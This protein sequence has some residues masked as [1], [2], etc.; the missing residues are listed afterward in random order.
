MKIREKNKISLLSKMI[1]LAVGSAVLSACQVD[2]SVDGT[3]TG[4]GDLLNVA[5]IA[6]ADS[7]SINEDGILEN[8]NVLANDTD[9]N[10]DVL[11]VSEATASTGSVVINGDNTLTY[12]PAADF[13]GE[14]VVT[15]TVNDGT[16]TAVGNLTVTVVAVN[17]DPVAVDDTVVVD[18]NS[19]ANSIAVLDNDSDVEDT[20]LTIDSA[21]A[22]FGQVDIVGGEILYT[23]LSDATENDSIVY[24]VSDS[25]GGSDTATVTVQINALDDGG[26]AVQVAAGRPIVIS[27]QPR[28][29]SENTDAANFNDWVRYDSPLNTNPPVISTDGSSITFNRTTA[30][31]G[32]DAR[33]YVEFR[34]GKRFAGAHISV[35]M[36]VTSLDQAATGVHGG[37]LHL[38]DSGLTGE[39]TRNATTTGTWA[40]VLRMDEDAEDIFVRV[41]LGAFENDTLTNAVTI[42]NVQVSY[43]VEGDSEPNEYVSGKRWTSSPGYNGA[44][45]PYAKDASYNEQTGFVTFNEDSSSG[46]SA[47]SHVMLITDSF[48]NFLSAYTRDLFFGGVDNL[49][50]SYVMSIDTL[51][52]RQLE[53][54]SDAVLLE[55]MY[56]L[57][58]H[59]NA[60]SPGVLAVHLGVNSFM[61]DDGTTADLAQVEL[62]KYI[63]FA[64]SRNMVAVITTATPFKNS[65]PWTQA[66]QD[67]MNLYNAHVRALEN[68]S[69]IRVVDLNALLDTNGDEIIEAEFLSSG[70]DYIHAFGPATAIM[71]NAYDQVF[72]DIITNAVLPVSPSDSL[73]AVINSSRT[74]CASP[75]TIVFSA[76]DTQG[77]A[78]TEHQVWDEVA[79]HW[80]FD[81]ASRSEL[82]PAS[83]TY[84]DGDP[85]R[86]VGGP[87]ATKTFFCDVGVCNYRV[88]VRA[89]NE[90]GEFDDAF[91]D[92]SVASEASQ[93]SAANTVCVSNTLNT[94]SDW[95]IFD[96][97]CPEGATKQ[98]DLPDPDSLSDRL[99]LLRKGDTF[100][101]NMATRMGQSNFKIGY[102]GQDSD[103]RPEIDGN[104]WIGASGISSPIEAPP[105]VSTAHSDNDVNTFGWS[106][107]I[108]IEGIR[109]QFVEFPMSYEHIGLH[110][111][112]LDQEGRQNGGGLNLSGRS[113]FCYTSTNLDCAN[114]PF[115]K[116]GYIS[117]T[118]IV[119]GDDALTNSAR[120]VLNV[121]SIGCGMNNYVGIVD[122]YFRK[123]GEHNL[124]MMG[125]W[126][127]NIMRSEFAGEHHSSGKQKLTTRGCVHGALDTGDW[128]VA[129]GIDN[130]GLDPEGRTRADSQQ[131]GSGNYIHLSR[132]M[133]IQGNRIGEPTQL[134][135][136]RGTTKIQTNVLGGDEPLMQDYLVTQN[137]FFNTD[138]D[139]TTDIGLVGEHMTCLDN[140]YSEGTGCHGSNVSR[141]NISI[142]P[143]PLSAPLAPGS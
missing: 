18:E 129:S 9:I 59:S 47:A 67:E 36:D 125:W 37:S 57:R 20:S 11:T 88:G 10:S 3:V 90:V 112:D 21:S 39:L 66:K 79:Y 117:S 55:E 5:P 33:D 111:V 76:D 30:N 135:T 26:Q 118:R 7:A 48:G 1:S 121:A 62:Q 56:A 136:Q 53:D 96:K 110:D 137:T 133:L 69:D 29:T 24:V 101:R 102:F 84:T 80:D 109:T 91:V 72:K 115:P 61:L 87:M 113:T 128:L 22:S 27:F 81:T 142:N 75:C 140:S 93:W 35:S 104:I 40:T 85:A 16:T 100:T 42:S 2:F 43:L 103:P 64:H 139:Q 86:E 19:I 107:N 25:E 106:K 44:A 127:T 60:S 54:T 49:P 116:G 23:P 63:D 34:F 58:G 8:V 65:A 132:Y 68:G 77:D 46:T 126:R 89:Q 130:M 73:N 32:L 14:A 122:S 114:V 134:G 124:R 123:A 143:T 138:G 92:I 99:V 105:S 45:L 6:V 119:G 141:D 28:S 71:Y 120:S 31:D 94:T 17:D 70:Q 95:T 131:E 4:E 98:V 50:A 41:G 51:A 78:L 12:T 52:G 74:Q 13:F 83:Y 82:Y 15:Y 108:T 38:P 97:A